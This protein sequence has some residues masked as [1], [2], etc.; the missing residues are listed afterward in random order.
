MICFKCKTEHAV[1]DESSAARIA[2]RLAGVPAN[3][4]TSRLCLLCADA[5]LLAA[6]D[7]RDVTKIEGDL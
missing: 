3:D 4:T 5:V 7:T 1:M 2:R 6:A